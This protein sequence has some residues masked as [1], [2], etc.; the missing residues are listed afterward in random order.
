MPFSSCYQHAAIERSTSSEKLYNDAGTLGS[1]R[2]SKAFVSCSRNQNHCIIPWS[3]VWYYKSE[4][5]LAAE[6]MADFEPIQRR[7]VQP[8][9]KAQARYDE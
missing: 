9:P 3:C 5:P 1:L 2:P 4:A 7:K 6:T 8:R